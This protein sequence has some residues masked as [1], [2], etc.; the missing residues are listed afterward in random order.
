[1]SG[2]TIFIL[3]SN[4]FTCSLIYRLFFGTSLKIYFVVHTV[5]EYP[6]KHYHPGNDK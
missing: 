3:L 4:F 2:L 5:I 6:I 1:M